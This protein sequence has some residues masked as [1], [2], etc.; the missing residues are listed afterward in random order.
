MVEHRRVS[1]GLSQPAFIPTLMHADHAAVV[2]DSDGEELCLEFN[3]RD[4]LV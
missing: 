4:E 2:E 3:D 1:V